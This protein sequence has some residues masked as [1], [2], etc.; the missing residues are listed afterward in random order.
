MSDDLKHMSNGWETLCGKSIHFSVNVI[1]IAASLR[2]VTCPKCRSSKKYKKALTDL[3]R[4]I[5]A[6]TDGGYSND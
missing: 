5:K 4:E 1:P 6:L 3:E 2:S